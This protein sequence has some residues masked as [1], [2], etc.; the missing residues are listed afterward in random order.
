MTIGGSLYTVIGDM[1]VST[2]LF[3]SGICFNKSLFD[4]S[5]IAYPYDDV[6]AGK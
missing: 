4:A 6:R 2:L 1:G 3:P 5:H